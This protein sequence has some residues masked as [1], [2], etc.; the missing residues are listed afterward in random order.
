MDPLLER[1]KSAEVFT[2]ALII[3][4][5]KHVKIKKPNKYESPNNHHLSYPANGLWLRDLPRLPRSSLGGGS[6]LENRVLLLLLRLKFRGD[7][8]LECLC[9]E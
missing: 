1:Y 5:K 9:Q 4:S 2:A 6:C 3:T 8:D 7:R